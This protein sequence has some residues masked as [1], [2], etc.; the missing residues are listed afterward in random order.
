M[1]I[2]RRV[3][4]ILV[5]LGA[6]LL[7]ARHDSAFETLP[8]P[9]TGLTVKMLADVRTEGDYYVK[10]SM[11]KTDQALGLASETVSCPLTINIRRE[12]RTTIKKDIDSLSR[13]AE[14]GF[15]KIQYY[16]SADAWHLTPGEY[17]VEVSSRD[18]CSMA[19]SRGATLT[20]EQE[21][22][23]LTERYLETVL[24]FW[25]GVVFLCAGLI[26]LIFCEFSTT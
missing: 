8:L 15:G 12:G 16:K 18:N 9:G 20:M 1:R 11:P 2:F 3:C 23:H 4:I 24:R 22:T 13:Y 6:F 14:F 10:V 19:M 5:A 17:E 7:F 26:G 25:S 21:V